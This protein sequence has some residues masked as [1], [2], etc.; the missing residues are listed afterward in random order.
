M[1]EIFLE[2]TVKQ[3]TVIWEVILSEVEWMSWMNDLDC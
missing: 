2:Q 3:L 1:A